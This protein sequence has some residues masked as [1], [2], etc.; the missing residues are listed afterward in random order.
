MRKHFVHIKEKFLSLAIR[1]RLL[2]FMLF[3]AI[4]P[5]IIV[6]N[7]SMD[8]SIKVIE[9]NA[10]KA[11]ISSIKMAALNINTLMTECIKQGNMISSD[12]LIRTYLKKAETPDLEKEDAKLND[13][14]M[15][16]KSYTIN[17]I[18]F[19]CV[20]GE[21]GLM[22]KST[23]SFFNDVDFR[24]TD[25]YQKV[26]VS[27]SPVW[28]DAHEDQFMV[29]NRSTYNYV[30][31]G[32][33]MVD[34][35]TGEKTGVVLIEFRED[36]IY[37]NIQHVTSNSNSQI[38]FYDADYNSVLR[39]NDN[40]LAQDIQKELRGYKISGVLDG[41]ISDAVKADIDSSLS[42]PT[43]G[44]VDSFRTKIN[45]E[46][47]FVCVANLVSGWKM[48]DVM[49]IDELSSN[50]RQIVPFSLIVALGVCLVAVFLSLQF[51]S[52]IAKPIKSLIGLMKKVEVG[53]FTGKFQV[54]YR[55]EI[56][57]L[58]KSYNLMLEEIQ[59][60]MHTVREEQRELNKAQ[61]KILQEQ[62]NP[63]FL[64]NTLDS[65]NWLSRMGRND[66]VVVIVNAF[67]KLMRIALNKG[68]DV[69]TVQEE[70]AHAQSYLT[71]QK[72]R[73]KKK[74]DFEMEIP[75]VMREYV[76]LKLIL[77]P[78]VEN[79]IYHGIKAKKAGGEIFV[80]GYEQQDCLVFTVKDT[81]VGFGESTL[82]EL[83]ENLQ[84]PFGIVWTGMDSFGIKNVSDR[85]KVFFG[86]RY[87]LRYESVLGEGTTVYITI[88]KL[89]KWEQT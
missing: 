64:Y 32:R 58:G 36:I 50:T 53:D 38:F 85:I 19:T 16:L 5:M 48:V 81:G 88:P 13:R 34:Q 71:I 73:Y 75:E 12:T 82:A 57:M 25:W 79:A 60:L 26:I 31:M 61:V 15:F 37:D 28:F 11:N 35:T 68:R 77:Q 18:S 46:E 14:L 49:S 4:I 21:N 47:Y 20:M 8:T 10:E 80:S 86:Y 33:P 45:G 39:T 17:D 41:K 52:S 6:L 29:V 54:K 27:D 89:R 72:I 65:I 78:I 30:T 22:I 3:L 59:R 70:A 23:Y 84:K 51:S 67:T 24:D 76:T 87:G 63:H 2:I 1:T 62:I 42:V 55:D 44:E 40:L 43:V 66:E 69:I 7:I 74:L 56:G 9:D 83:N